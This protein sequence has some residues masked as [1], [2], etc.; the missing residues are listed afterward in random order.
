MKLTIDVEKLK[1]TA[2]EMIVNFTPKFVAAIVLLFVGL[3]VIRKLV[4]FFD[5]ILKK[6]EFDVTLSIF[7]ESLL[8]W[9]LKILLFISVASMVG[10]ATTSFVALIG[11]AGLA[12][13]LA[14]QGSLGHFAGGV[15]LMVFKP[16]KIGDYIIAQGEEGTVRKINVFATELTKLSNMRV[17]LPNGPLAG[18]SIVNVTAE[19][20]RRVDL[21][22]GIDYKDNIQTAMKALIEMCDS[23]EKT[24]EEPKAF[25]GVNSYGDSSIN[26]I[27]RAW[28]NTPDYWEVFYDLNKSIKPTL[29]KAGI[30][31]PFP[32]RDVHLFN[33]K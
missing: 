7:L 27:V 13:G 5:K 21:S 26:L 1:D 6:K 2:T 29:D 3:Y 19:P 31:I 17:I 28:C 10:I 24:I 25:V 11:A 8:S 30:S 16:F 14:L 33:E 18:G 22:V 12:V 20:I 32:Q 15:L 9:G 4:R 23:H